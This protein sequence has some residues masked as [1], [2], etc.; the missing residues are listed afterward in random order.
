MKKL[1]ISFNLEFYSSPFHPEIKTVK[2][3]VEDGFIAEL[4]EAMFNS[5]YDQIRKHYSEPENKDFIDMNE[6]LS[7]AALKTL[8]YN[9]LEKKDDFEKTQVSFSFDYID[10]APLSPTFDEFVNLLFDSPIKIKQF[11]YQDITKRFPDRVREGGLDLY[12]EFIR[13]F[14]Q[15]KDT[16][17][18]RFIKDNI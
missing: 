15:A 16:I 2:D 6:N 5:P 10:D 18:I 1:L 13:S 9:V 4:S 12:K 17:S 7:Q 8:Q 11:I 3:F 14:T